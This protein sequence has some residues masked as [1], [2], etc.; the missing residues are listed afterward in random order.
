MKF[1]IVELI[2]NRD[3][4]FFSDFIENAHDYCDVKKETTEVI[5]FIFKTGYWQV[6]SKLPKR[7]VETLHLPGAILQEN[8]KDLGDFLDGREKYLKY[9]IPYK[10]NYLF[11]GLPG[12]G[13]T[14]F[15]FV[16]ASHFDMNLAIINFSMSVDDATFMKS[17]SKLPDNCFLVLEDID[18]LFVERKRGDAHKS[19]VSF[20]GILNTLD[21]I[22]RRDKQ[23]TFLTTNYVSKLDTALVRPGRIDKI[24][25][26]SYATPNQIEKFFLKFIPAQKDKL[27]NFKKATQ[28]ISKQR[29]RFF[30]VFSLNM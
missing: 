10:R 23:V 12:T 18:A 11:E 29:R 22:A 19:M 7:N 13:K 20:S 25:T 3:K 5:T 16:L 9:G 27:D 8:I 15:I 2:A 30:K 21:G 1:H 17:V 4:S 26:F 6:L 28:R 14:S 24:I